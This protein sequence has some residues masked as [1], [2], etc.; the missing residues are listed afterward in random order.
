MK[1]STAF[2]FASIADKFDKLRHKDYSDAGVDKHLVLCQATQDNKES[3]CKWSLELGAD[4]YSSVDETLQEHNHPDM[5]NANC[6]PCI[7]SN[8]LPVLTT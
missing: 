7:L 2:L 1:E 5:N 6:S 8:W 4:P 3:V